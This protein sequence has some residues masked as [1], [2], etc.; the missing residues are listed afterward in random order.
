MKE[1]KEEGERRKEFWGKKECVNR[2][3]QKSSHALRTFKF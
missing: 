2:A 3:R 1:I